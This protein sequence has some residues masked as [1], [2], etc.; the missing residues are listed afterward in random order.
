[1]AET[2]FHTL[3]IRRMRGKPLNRLRWDFGKKD[4]C[5]W[6]YGNMS[7]Q[8]IVEMLEFW[9]DIPVGSAITVTKK[10]VKQ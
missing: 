9:I 3:N 7:R 5:V 8:E 1:M 6:I 10:E 2:G 4:I